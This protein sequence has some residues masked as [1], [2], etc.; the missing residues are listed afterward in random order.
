MLYSTWEDF[1]SFPTSSAIF[2]IRCH[3]ESYCFSEIIHGY[4][5]PTQFDP[6]L[7]FIDHDSPV[8]R[9]RT[10]GTNN[11][12]VKMSLWN[13]ATVH[14]HAPLWPARCQQLYEVRLCWRVSK[15]NMG[16]RLCDIVEYVCCILDCDRVSSVFS[17]PKFPDISEVWAYINHPIMK[18]QWTKRKPVSYTHLTLPTIYSV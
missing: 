12:F 18:V 7:N 9:A 11:C 14:W 17:T 8:Q 2:S 13:P 1:I 15:Y 5:W 10:L 16:Y 4:K 6:A 3:V